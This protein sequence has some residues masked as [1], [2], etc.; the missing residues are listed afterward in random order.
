MSRSSRPVVAILSLSTVAALVVVLSIYYRYH[1]SSD[2]VQQATDR[3]AARYQWVE[4]VATKGKGA[5]HGSE[6]ARLLTS[7]F[8]E[9]ERAAEYEKVLATAQWSEKS[10]STDKGG[11]SD[12]AVEYHWTFVVEKPSHPDETGYMFWV[13]V[14]GCPP[15]IQWLGGGLTT[16]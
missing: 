1:R 13:R 7:C 11:E 3:A 6:N 14:G 16:D 2:P 15:K 9:G 8:K 10:P 4:L 12:G 5:L